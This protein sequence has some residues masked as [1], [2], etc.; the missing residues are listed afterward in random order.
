MGRVVSPKM[1]RQTSK[2]A[3]DVEQQAL[4]AATIKR[5]TQKDLTVPKF[6]Q[7]ILDEAAG[8]KKG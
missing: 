1:N 4:A 3:T 8:K 7:D 2:K 6:L 5:L